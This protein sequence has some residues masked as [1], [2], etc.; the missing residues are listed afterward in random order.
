MRL[1]AIPVLDRLP[2]IA[3]PFFRGGVITRLQI[4]LHTV[5]G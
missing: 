4:F 3:E 2:K 5:D 1:A